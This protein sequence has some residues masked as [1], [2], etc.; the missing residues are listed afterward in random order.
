M[1]RALLA[2]AAAYVALTAVALAA[3]TASFEFAPAQ[4][5][6]QETVTFTSTSSPEP[7]AGIAAYAW[8]LDGDS[9]FGE[10]GEPSGPSADRAARAFPAGDHVVRLRVTGTDGS[11]DV[12]TRVVA[13]REPPPGEQPPPGGDPPPPGEG[14][15][16][17]QEP[18]LPFA[19]PAAGDDDGD[20]VGDAADRCALTPRGFARVAYGCALFELM[21]SPGIVVEPLAGAVGDARDEVRRLP[22]LR[23]ASRHGVRLGRSLGAMRRAARRLPHDPCGARRAGRAAAAQ[24]RGAVAGITR[25]AGAGQT[26]VGR[27]ATR[28]FRRAPAEERDASAFDVA[29]YELEFARREARRARRAMDGAQRLMARACASSAAVKPIRG[30]VQSV[31]PGGLLRLANGATIALGGARG[32]GGLA[33]GVL[34]RGRG[35]SLRGSRRVSVLSSLVTSGK[36][37]LAACSF[38]LRIAPVQE[39]ASPDEIAY[40]DD[41][42][43]RL[44]NGYALETGMRFGAVRGPTCRSTGAENDYLNVFLDFR[45]ETGTQ[46][47]VLL[48]QLSGAPGESSAPLGTHVVPEAGVGGT[49]RVEALHTTCS[50]NDVA[51]CT[52]TER[53]TTSTPTAVRRQGGWATVQP[54]AR[55]YAGGDGDPGTYDVAELASVS[56]DL[57]GASPLGVGY[58]VAGGTRSA[59]PSYLGPGEPFAVVHDLPAPLPGDFEDGV[60]GVPGGLI[61]AYAVGSRGGNPYVYAARVESIVTDMLHSCIS[62]PEAA[63]YRLPWKEGTLGQTTQGNDTTFSHKGGQRF[64]YDFVMPLWTA[65]HATRGGL[66]DLVI[67]NRTETSNPNEDDPWVPGNV[68]RVHHQDDTYSWYEHM[69]PNGVTPKEGQIIDRGDRVLTV[70][71]TGNSTGPHLHYHVSMVAGAEQAGG[72]NASRGSTVRARFEAREVLPP[73]ELQPCL[74]PADDSVWRSTNVD[75]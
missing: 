71:N 75:R 4:P 70:G 23:R 18:G 20:G 14:P 3:P 27:D 65:G 42:G 8:D 39:A 41:A 35:V 62:S 64:A 40:Y 74:V 61:A 9:V 52:V 43:F 67:E 68:L 26:S 24:A 19:P 73:F 16:P 6:P 21:A 55:T 59:T 50:G 17:A 15:P 36:V 47:S 66:V 10:P 29:F 11:E 72:N 56:G 33:P 22:L 46:R 13:V 69:A 49:L 25:V 44:G 31:E 38:R 37:K 32:V 60:R 12:A 63:F 2:A 53:T 7:G 51:V 58:A 57:P 48:E 1:R 28:F 30:R 45:D 54:D 5:K 34:V